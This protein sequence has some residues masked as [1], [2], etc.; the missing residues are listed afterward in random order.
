MHIARCLLLLFVSAFLFACSSDVSHVRYMPQ[1]E[2]IETT[3]L[4]ICDKKDNLAEINTQRPINVFIHG[5]NSSGGIDFRALAQVFEFH[6]Q[7]T[8]CFNYN[9]RDSLEESSAELIASLNRLTKQMGM[10]RITVIGHSQGGL[11]ARR[12]F[13]K[14]RADGLA[15]LPDANYRLITISSPFAGISA[16]EHCGLTILHIASLGISMGACQLI[17]GSKWSEIHP[18]SDFMMNPGS[19][20]QDVGSYLKIVTDERNTCLI[21]DED[22]SCKE[23]DFVFSVKEQ[24]NATIDSDSRL[25]NIEV[26]AGHT[27]IVGDKDIAPKKLIAILQ[28]NAILNPT[29]PERKKEFETLLSFLY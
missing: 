26:K 8:L 5:C 18:G 12:A 15:L 7:Q 23:D 9:D 21:Y 11:V 17:T 14:D 29:P 19:L 16:S 13:I 3:G 22:G 20:C 2:V 6:G 27:E 10:S 1:N 25:K 4:A 24:Y 28:S